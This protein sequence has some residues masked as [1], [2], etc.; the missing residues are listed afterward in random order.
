MRGQHAYRSIDSGLV[1]GAHEKRTSQKF[2]QAPLKAR[3]VDGDVSHL[4]KSATK[5]S[6]MMDTICGGKNA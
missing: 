3:L 4:R 6:C 1:P 2:A 5:G